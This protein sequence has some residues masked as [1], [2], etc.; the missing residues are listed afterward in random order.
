MIDNVHDF[1]TFFAVTWQLGLV[2]RE[3]NELLRGLLTRQQATRPSRTAAT[4][5]AKDGR[6]QL[7]QRPISDEDVCPICQEEFLEKH[8]PVT[9]CKYGCA[10]NVH[11]KCMK[12]WAEHQKSIGDSK[13]RFRSFF[14][15]LSIRFYGRLCLN[16]RLH[17]T[18]LTSILSTTKQFLGLDLKYIFQKYIDMWC[19]LQSRLRHNECSSSR[20]EGSLSDVDPT[21]TYRI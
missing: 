2:E 1:W 19:W 5:A 13:F 3:I 15:R 14:I 11:I 18:G 12:I 9:F 17:R 16:L 8:E 20:L 10:Q 7:E 21:L 4:S 6:Q